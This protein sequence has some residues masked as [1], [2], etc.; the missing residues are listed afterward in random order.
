MSHCGKESGQRKVEMWEGGDGKR[1]EMGVREMGGHGS[2]G[3]LPNPKFPVAFP[4]PK[5][6]NSP[7]PSEILSCADGDENPT[8]PE[9]LDGF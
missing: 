1:L 7:F 8:E 2:T 6:P 9:C 4:A 5:C 3:R